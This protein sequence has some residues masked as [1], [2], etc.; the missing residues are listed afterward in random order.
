MFTLT[1]WSGAVQS[2]HSRQIMLVVA[3][4]ACTGRQLVVK[5]A[6]LSLMRLCFLVQHRNPLDLIRGLRAQYVASGNAQ[7]DGA[8][9]AEAFNWMAFA[10]DVARYF[11]HA[12]GLSCM[13]GPMDAAPKVCCFLRKQRS[14]G[15]HIVWKQY[16]HKYCP[17]V[18]RRMRAQSMAGRRLLL[19]TLHAQ[20]I[21]V[22]GR[23]GTLRSLS[24]RSS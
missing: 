20:V 23:R 9:V 21:L 2:L 24:T 14:C 5:L 16:S 22:L 1:L 3:S 13:L 10:R 19:R 6:D 18:Y 11:K 12:P 4:G 7:D 17:S 8:N 15:G